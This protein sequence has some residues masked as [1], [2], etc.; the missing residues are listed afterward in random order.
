[1]TFNFE[2]G[3]ESI[4]EA[5]QEV[6]ATIFKIPQDPLDLIQPDW[7]T[8]LSEALECYNVTTEEEDK[9]PR[10][11]NIPE[12][13]GHYEVEGLQLENLDI[14]KLLKTRQVNIDMEEEPKFAKI[15]DYWDDAT[16]DKVT[17][18][19]H[20]YQDLFPMKFS[21]M[22]GIIGDLGVTKITLKL[23]IKPMKKRHYRIHL[24]G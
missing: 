4:D 1:M 13:E 23:D 8:Q 5:L 7:T 18:L 20:K 22:K 21:D 14:T 2:D 6:K 11:I 24:S 15:R 9:D 19:L 10:K 3:F 12:T 17:K 16:V